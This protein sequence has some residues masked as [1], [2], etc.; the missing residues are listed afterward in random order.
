L[1]IDPFAKIPVLMRIFVG[2]WHHFYWSSPHV[3]GSIP[4]SVGEN[5]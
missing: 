5:S 4:L 3:E 2:R 1:N